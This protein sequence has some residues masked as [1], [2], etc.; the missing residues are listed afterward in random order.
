MSLHIVR[1]FYQDVV[2]Q[3]FEE[4]RIFWEEEGL[5]ESSMTDLKQIWEAKLMENGMDINADS[6]AADIEYATT[7]TSGRGSRAKNQTSVQSTAAAGHSALSKSIAHQQQQSAQPAQAQ[8]QPQGPQQPAV[9]QQQQQPPA[10][11]TQSQPAQPSQFQHHPTQPVNS[12]GPPPQPQPRTINVQT[13]QNSQL[14]LTPTA[15]M[16]SAKTGHNMAAAGQQAAFNLLTTSYSGPVVHLSSSTVPTNVAALSNAIRQQQQQQQ[17]QNLN[18]T[19]LTVNGTAA[20]LLFANPHAQY[21]SVSQPGQQPQ[22]QILASDDQRLQSVIQQHSHSNIVQRGHQPASAAVQNQ[23]NVHS[24]QQKVRQAGMASFGQQQFTLNQNQANATVFSLANQGYQSAGL[25]QHSVIHVVDSSGNQ[26][27]MN[28]I[29]AVPNSA[30]NNKSAAAVAAAAVGARKPGQPLSI[31]LD[32]MDDDD[33]FE[34]LSD[35][36]PSPPKSNRSVK[37][38]KTSRGASQRLE[39]PDLDSEDDDDNDPTNGGDAVDN[40]VVCQYEKVS[41]TRNKW[42]LHLKSGMCSLNGREYIF[43]KAVGDAEF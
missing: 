19:F 43:H 31:Q 41:R 12:Q 37:R 10:Q 27:P 39:E 6:T 13:I 21:R 18:P 17:Q 5:D 32:G 24:I 40:V 23:I 33:D 25:G 20:Q 22:N 2:E 26:Q 11:L 15:Q 4:S 42:K 8:Q 16:V 9:Q 35:D 36:E 1:K 7:K 30:I 28:V 14:N 3:L 38:L 34:D 29:S